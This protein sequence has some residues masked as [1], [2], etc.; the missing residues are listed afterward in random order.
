MPH[1][2][3]SSPTTQRRRYVGFQTSS[4]KNRN[5]KKIHPAKHTLNCLL[6]FAWQFL[7]NFQLNFMS[8]CEMK[9]RRRCIKNGSDCNRNRK[10]T[11]NYL[12]GWRKRKKEYIDDCMYIFH[13]IAILSIVSVLLHDVRLNIKLELYDDLNEIMRR[14]SSNGL[15]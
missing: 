15:R 8:F 5:K 13:S 6:L 3:A 9:N 11:T 7:F 10:E 2:P 12:I 1:K 4:N 14:F